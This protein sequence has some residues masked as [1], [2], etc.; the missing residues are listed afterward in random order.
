VPPVRHLS[1]T[2]ANAEVVLVAPAQP[3]GDVS[4]AGMLVPRDV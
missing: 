1:V 4:G 2:I 3:E